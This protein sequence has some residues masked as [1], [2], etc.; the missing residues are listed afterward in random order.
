ML[1]C[2][3][4]LEF[5]LMLRN[6]N[7]KQRK[8]D[9]KNSK[10]AIFYQNANGRMQTGREKEQRDKKKLER[11]LHIV[12]LEQLA[13]AASKSDSLTITVSWTLPVRHVI[14]QDISFIVRRFHCSKKIISFFFL[15]PQ[16][17]TFSFCR[18]N[19]T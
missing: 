14:L 19:V 8:N 9:K 1:A 13:C 7:K 2:K 3:F 16:S 18:W 6:E 12:E 10:N 17:P 5:H 11:H 15:A 4:N